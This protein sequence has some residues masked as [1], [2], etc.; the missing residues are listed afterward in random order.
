MSH[1]A[2]VQNGKVLEVLVA[3]QDFIDNYQDNR[4]GRWVQTS[5]N[6]IGGVHYDPET[7]Q[8]SADQSKALRKNFA[9]VGWNYDITVDAFY[10][11]QPFPSWRLN[12]T[13]YMWEPPVEQPVDGNQYIWNEENQ[14]WDAVE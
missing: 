2:K 3:T 12:E 5:Y 6:T 1:F 4:S 9:S 11:P 13:T 14:S 7:N 8:P 10:A